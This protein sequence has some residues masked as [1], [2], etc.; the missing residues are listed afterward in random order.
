MPSEVPEEGMGE[1]EGKLVKC[2]FCPEWMG[3]A[4]LS[5][6]LR[7]FHRISLNV[8]P[9]RTYDR[10]TQTDGHIKVRKRQGGKR[11]RSKRPLPAL[12]TSTPKKN[13][14]D[15][16]IEGFLPSPRPHDTVEDGEDL[17]C[18]YIEEGINIKLESEAEPEESHVEQ[19]AAPAKPRK[20]AVKRQKRIKSKNKSKYKNLD[21]GSCLVYSF[22]DA[23]EESI[24]DKSPKRCPSRSA[25]SLTYSSDCPQI[26]YISVTKKHPNP[27]SGYEQK[28]LKKPA[29]KGT[30]SKRKRE[31]GNLRDSLHKLFLLPT[32]RHRKRS[33]TH[34][35][36]DK[37]KYTRK[38][39]QLSKLIERKQGLKAHKSKA[40]YS[41]T[42]NLTQ[43]AQRTY[44]GI[45][46]ISF[47]SKKGKSTP[48]KYTKTDSSKVISRRRSKELSG[49][50]DYLSS[51]Y[52]PNSSHRHS[53]KKR[54]KFKVL[55]DMSQMVE[56]KSAVTTE[57][58]QKTKKIVEKRKKVMTPIYKVVNME[59]VE[60]LRPLPNISSKSS[61]RNIETHTYRYSDN[62]RRKIRR[63]LINQALAA[64]FANKAD[65]EGDLTAA[66]KPNI[67]EPRRKSIDLAKPSQVLK[68]GRNESSEP[69]CT[70]FTCS[71][72]VKNFKCR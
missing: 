53:N 1:C 52:V 18:T 33:T 16:N 65:R 55:H 43:A 9:S 57:K 71:W 68:C 42:D 3:E 28:S 64:S 45:S 44:K 11:K 46:T 70:L 51:F 58:E 36:L 69:P 39:L 6:H 26:N 12:V 5:R 60:N 23:A 56:N 38:S 59:D 10:A 7:D 61:S 54:N 24:L 32:S 37:Q 8:A 17:E 67:P 20:L 25:N 15:G 30:V 35:M 41:N 13:Q 66:E 72:C 4:E 62:M 47:Y 63:K 31:L 49:L 48:F 40:D 14:L 2:L 34:R 29:G 19:P 50:Q 27:I 21:S 22:V